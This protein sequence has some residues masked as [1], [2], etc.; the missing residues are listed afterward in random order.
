MRRFQKITYTMDFAD[1]KDADLFVEV[2]AEDMATK[3]AIISEIDAI[4]KE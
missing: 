3:H 1:C 4:A 2:I